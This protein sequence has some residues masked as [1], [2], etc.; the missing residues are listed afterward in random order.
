VKEQRD[1]VLFL[2][3]LVEGA[4]DKSYGIAVAR[5]AGLPGQVIER[6]KQVLAGFEKGERVSLERLAPAESDVALAA[7]RPSE[8]EPVLARL[9][10]VN[11][12][13]LSPL[14][15]YSLLVELRQALVR[16]A[17]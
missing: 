3:K 6:A 17:G 4:A 10:S 7:D 11:P 1:N 12:D 15:A 9:R 16:H 5:L 8:S 2:R 14:Q 13:E